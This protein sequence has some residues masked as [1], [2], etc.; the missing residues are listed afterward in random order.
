MALLTT[1][2]R[3][4]VLQEFAEA[5]SAARDPLSVATPDMEAGILAID[6]WIDSN[7]ASFIAAM[8]QPFRGGTTTRQKLDLFTR[9][10]HKRYLKS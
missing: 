9:V 1:E 7:Q 10:A 8:P 5:T 3:A 4:A 6:T 2:E